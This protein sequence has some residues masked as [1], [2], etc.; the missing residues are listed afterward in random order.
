MAKLMDIKGYW[1]M[2]YGYDF[3]DRDMWEGQILLQDDGWFEGIVVDP[4][5]SY[6]ED[7]FIFG[8]Y[9]PGKVVELFKFTPLS[10]SAPFVFHGRR[11]AKGYE[12]Q[13]ETIGLFGTMP[14]GTSHIITQYAEV[15]RGN[16]DEEAKVLEAKIQRY[17]SSIID[18]SGQEFYDNTIAI[19]KTMTQSV[20]RNYEGKGFTSEEIDE[21]REE[22]EPVNEKVIKATEE[23]VKKLVKQM[24]KDLF[25]EDDGLPF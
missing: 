9:Y 20:F 18:K 22:F 8:V 14:C 6:T 10:V 4:S 16:V 15:A 25:A 21:L 12:G 2:S 24:P 1:N 3:N 23:D 17:K 7:R 11:D 13:F 5:S 19:R